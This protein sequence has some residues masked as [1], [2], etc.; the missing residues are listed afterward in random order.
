MRAPNPG[1]DE[2]GSFA[3]DVISK[4]PGATA[5]PH[6]SNYAFRRDIPWSWLV[7]VM[8]TTETP[9][10]DEGNGEGGG[11]GRRMDISGT[12]GPRQRRE[13]RRCRA[14]RLD[15]VTVRATLIDQALARSHPQDGAICNS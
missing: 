7:A 10:G 2:R 15:E 3:G 6:P 11:W 1:V 12:L 8:M 14:L 9:Y 4:R 5:R 13:G